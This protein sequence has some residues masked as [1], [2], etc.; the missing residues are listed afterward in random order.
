MAFNDVVTR[1]N[2]EALIPEDV[3]NQI[4]QALPQRSSIMQLGR[5]LPPMA[6]DQRRMPIMT[7]LGIAGFVNGDT[8]L[9]ATTKQAWGNKFLDAEEIAV[10]VPIPEN[11]LDDT[12]YDIWGEVR[13]RIE[14][15][16]GIVFDAAVMYDT[17]GFGGAA[18]ASW[19]TGLVAGATAAG[20]TVALGT[21]VDL[22]ED[23]LGENGTLSLVE[24]DGY[25]VT[26]HV[27][28]LSMKSKLRG[29][30]DATG[31]PLFLSNMQDRTRYELD[32]S[33]TYFPTNGAVDASSSLL[34]SGDWNQLVWAIRKDITYKVLDQAVI[35]DAAGNIIYNLAQQDMVALRAVMRI[36]WQLPN[37]INRVNSND[38]TRY[39]FAV[40]TPA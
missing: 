20:H 38:A 12:D 33:P 9:K 5:R 11:V 6:R 29:L 26:G 8:G 24:Q 18:P 31:Q 32:G 40:L 16:F 4:I 3:S 36:A 7:A 23:I 22:Y 39:P 10:I 19:P 30:R 2:A 14:E 35:Q 1:S 34:L 37:P 17:D 21:G 28:S 25:L 27:A 13:P 15:S